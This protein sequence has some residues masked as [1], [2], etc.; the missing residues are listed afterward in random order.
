M[1]DLEIVATFNTVTEATVA[2]SFLHANGIEAHLKNEQFSALIG[3]GLG[4]GGYKI[5]VPT[6]QIQRA[7]ELLE[8]PLPS[9]STE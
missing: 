1:S 5:A 4:F 7:K 8:N 6:G 3:S 9:T 2:I